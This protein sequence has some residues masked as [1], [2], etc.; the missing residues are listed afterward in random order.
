MCDITWSGMY[1]PCI[2]SVLCLHLFV[3]V[4]HTPGHANHISVSFHV[5]EVGLLTMMIV[6]WF[7]NH[8]MTP[9][10]LILTYTVLFSLPHLIAMATLVYHILKR[11][12]FLRRLLQILFEKM[13]HGTAEV[14]NM[15][16]LL[17]GRVQNWH[18]Y[19]PLAHT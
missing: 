6:V 9:Q 13:F 11:I 19:Q 10:S 16:D 17:P 12:H 2:H 8:I 3:F 15:A 18:A 1:I 7:D 5:L 4:L 14:Q